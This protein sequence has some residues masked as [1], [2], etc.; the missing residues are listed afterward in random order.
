MSFRAFK[1]KFDY[2]HQ[3]DRLR[4]RKLWSLFRVVSVENNSLIP[5]VALQTLQ[6]QV[7]YVSPAAPLMICASFELSLH[8]LTNLFKFPSQNI[9]FK[10]YSKL[11]NTFFFR[12]TLSCSKSLSHPDPREMACKKALPKTFRSL[13]MRKKFVLMGARWIRFKWVG[14]K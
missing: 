5:H 9:T 14:F 12:S 10:I 2:P 6:K 13:Y 11:H 7:F 4:L 1:L 3:H 8:T